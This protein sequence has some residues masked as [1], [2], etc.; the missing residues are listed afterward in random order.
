MPVIS[1]AAS[2]ATSKNGGFVA[3]LKKDCVSAIHGNARLT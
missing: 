1:E 3:S 2:A